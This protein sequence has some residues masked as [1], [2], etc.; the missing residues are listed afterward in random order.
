MGKALATEY[1]P[2]IPNQGRA[3][4]IRGKPVLFRLPAAPMV[5]GRL[6]LVPIIPTGEFY[7]QDL[8]YFVITKTDLYNISKLARERSDLLQ[9]DYQHAAFDHN[10][11]VQ[12]KRAAGWIDRR[13]LFIAPWGRGYILMGWA[14]V[15]PEAA[16][17]RS[18]GELLYISP[19]VVKGQ[20]EIGRPGA[21]AGQQV[22]WSLINVALVDVPFFDMPPVALFNKSGQTTP[23]PSLFTLFGVNSMEELKSALAQF[24]ATVGVAADL[25]PSAVEGIMQL[26]MQ[27]QAAAT[28]A[29]AA[30][31]PAAMQA[32]PVIAAMPAAA[33]ATPAAFG[34][35][36]G[37]PRLAPVA[38]PPF[39]GFLPQQPQPL[40]QPQIQRP[41]VDPQ[42]VALF[43]AMQQIAGQVSA[44]TQLANQ[45]HAAQQ[46]EAA[47]QQA[48]AYQQAEA[49][50]QHA[51]LQFA[52]INPALFAQLTPQAYQ[53]AVAQPL[54]QGPNAFSPLP[55]PV[56]PALFGGL[57]GLAAAKGDKGKQ[58]YD[59]V[60]TY[61]K[62]QSATGRNIDYSTAMSEARSHG[63]LNGLE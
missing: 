5:G 32:A 36:W 4:F 45:G 14:Y 6:A 49:N 43:G 7:R 3:L 34:F 40:Q 8:G 62:G 38:Q 22:G 16:Q 50:G 21:P 24:L 13:S 25:I 23:R 59:R 26:Y 63:L 35:G 20:R 15:T 29:P 1:V 47:R 10:A 55:R 54:F 41:A 57:N 44:L 53:Q 58:I 27:A 39:F 48:A 30:A 18:K 56:I 52:G 46:A 37:Q 17:R 28:Q 12:E 11:P 61:Q 19:S 2:F 31:M 42:V 60:Q 51:A 33:P 9:I